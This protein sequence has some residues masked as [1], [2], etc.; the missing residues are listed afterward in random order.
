MKR[1]WLMIGLG[2][3]VGGA[4]GYSQ[5]FCPDGNCQITGSWYGGGIIGGWLGLLI[6]QAPVAR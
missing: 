6:G 4:L 3:L 1:R 2:A 5:V